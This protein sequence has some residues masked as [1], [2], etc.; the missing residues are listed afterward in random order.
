MTMTDVRGRR[1]EVLWMT[2]HEVARFRRQ[3]AH[4]PGLMRHGAMVHRM[5][6][7]GNPSHVSRGFAQACVWVNGRR[8]TLFLPYL[9]KE[10]SRCCYHC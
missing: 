8:D 3:S 1:T 2:R 4:R 6:M 5:T 7:R 9:N 10:A